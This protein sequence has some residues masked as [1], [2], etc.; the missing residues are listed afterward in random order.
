MIRGGLLF[1]VLLHNG[2][3]ADLPPSLWGSLPPCGDRS[4]GA[5]ARSAR[6]PDPP[7][8]IRTC[9]PMI[10]GLLLHNGIEADCNNGT[11]LRA[12]SGNELAALFEMVRK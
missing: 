1:V 11:F 6:E 7:L 8:V 4:R 9:G 12:K 3:E 2:I 10:R 5:R